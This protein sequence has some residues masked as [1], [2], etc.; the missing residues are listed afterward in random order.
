[1]FRIYLSHWIRGPKG[2]NATKEE[3]QYNINKFIRIGQEI[4]AYLLDWEKM[5]GF[6][7][8]DL[9]IPAEHDEFVQ[10]AFDRNYLKEEQILDVDC[11]IINGCNLVIVY[12]DYKLSR[13][14][15]VEIEHATEMGIPIYFMPSMDSAS[16]RSLNF[17]I[18]MILKE[19]EE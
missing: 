18:R 4:Q 17:A 5:D 14:M 15:Q 10:I 11:G 6:P 12:G 8:M 19:G 9:Y 13:G 1:M 2:K 16:I 3:I 7:K